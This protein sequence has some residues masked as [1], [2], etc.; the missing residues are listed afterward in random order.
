MKNT[1]M[2]LLGSGVSIPAGFPT[3]QKITDQVFSGNGVIQ[4]TDGRYYL[5]DSPTELEKHFSEE[6]L[7]SILSLIKLIKQIMQSY[8]KKE[9]LTYEILFYFILQLDDFES[10]NSVNMA[11]Y[12][13]YREVKEKYLQLNRKHTRFINLFA[14]TETYIRHIV[15]RMILAVNISNAGYL[16]FLPEAFKDEKLNAVNIA[17]LNHDLLLETYLDQQ[18]ISFQDGFG[19]SENGVRYWENNFLEKNNLLKLHGS[20]NWF[21][22]QF[23]GGSW[24]DERIGIVLDGDIDH[25]RNKDGRLMRSR[26]PEPLIL[27]GT[28]NKVGEYTG[29]IYSDIYSTFKTLLKTT[30]YLVVSGYSF[31]DKGINTAIVEWLFNNIRNK[32]VVIHPDSS[33]LL[34]QV[35]RRAI[36]R[37]A[38]DIAPENFT[39]LAKSIEKVSWGEIKKLLK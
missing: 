5:N 21:T 10:G 4:Y 36:Q 28:F 25:S 31:G 34:K 22:L 1:L 26:P 39:T 30:N 33:R 37:I 12:P 20:I 15:W 27:T 16:S 29:S 11:L 8:N 13:F 6:N 3:T 23:N 38:N 17:T 9:P 14:E 18:N 24:F 32:I 7:P 2:F 19:K 35:A